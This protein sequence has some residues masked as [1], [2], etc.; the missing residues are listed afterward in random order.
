MEMLGQ[1]TR[2]SNRDLMDLFQAHPKIQGG[3]EGILGLG[4]SWLEVQ[5]LKPEL[6]P[7]APIA[8]AIIAGGRSSDHPG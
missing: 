8:V 7:L 4:S 1:E 5:L 3:S 6:N 2:I